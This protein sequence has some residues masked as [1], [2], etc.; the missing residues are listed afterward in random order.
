MIYYF[1]STP[2][3]YIYLNLMISHF[4]VNSGSLIERLQSSL[5]VFFCIGAAR[6][7]QIDLVDFSEKRRWIRTKSFDGFAFCLD[8]RSVK[9]LVH[10]EL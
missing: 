7:A 4:V 8:I 10:S 9:I 2:S 5:S 6:S 1:P 3:M